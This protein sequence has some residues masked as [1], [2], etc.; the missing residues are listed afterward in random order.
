MFGIHPEPRVH[1]ALRVV[2][3][4]L[5]ALPACSDATNPPTSREVELQISADVGEGVIASAI[6]G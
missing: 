6:E 5:L 1:G 2:G 3:F 4:F